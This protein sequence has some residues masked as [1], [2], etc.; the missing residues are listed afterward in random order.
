MR[1]GYDIYESKLLGPIGM[2]VSE[3]G[4]ERIFLLEEN[5]STYLESHVVMGSVKKDSIC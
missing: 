1:R 2:V 4:L 5:L 3:L